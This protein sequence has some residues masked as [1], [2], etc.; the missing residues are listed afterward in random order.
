MAELNLEF[1]DN[2]T[3]EIQN[4]HTY[5]DNKIIKLSEYA[6]E[7]LTN[8]ENKTREEK[9]KIIKRIQD[10][11]AQIRAYIEKQVDAIKKKI[12]K[13]IADMTSYITDQLS[14]LKP[15]MSPPT[16]I[17]AVISW[18]SSVANYFAGPYYKLLKMQQELI[19]AMLKLSNA[20]IDLTT[21]DHFSPL[22]SVLDRINNITI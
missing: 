16:S 11:I 13:Y 4:L 3:K 18:A 12:D 7:Q 22:S 8:I 20:M 10:K 2:M 9:Q 5:I 19:E 21:H 1:V 17:G 15:I 6:N 14:V